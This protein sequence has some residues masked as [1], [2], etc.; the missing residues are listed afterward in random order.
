[1]NVARGMV[2]SRPVADAHGMEAAD[3]WELL[4]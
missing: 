3:W 2:T 1:V 4:S